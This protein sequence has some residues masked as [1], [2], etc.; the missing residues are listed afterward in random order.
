MFMGKRCFHSSAGTSVAETSPQQSRRLPQPR[1]TRAFSLLIDFPKE[2]CRGV[3]IWENAQEVRAPGYTYRETALAA[4]RDEVRRRGD[5][6]TAIKEDTDDRGHA[7]AKE[8][9]DEER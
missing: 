5:G 7:G 1:D 6:G 4:G 3:F 9:G 2:A 8:N